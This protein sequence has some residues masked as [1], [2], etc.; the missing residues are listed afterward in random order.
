MFECLKV[1]LINILAIL[2]MS[3]KFA[4]LDLLK[5]KGFWSKVYDVIKMFMTKISIM[6]LK[7]YCRCGHVTKIW[8]LY[9]FYE[10]SY[11]SLNFYKDLTRKNN[12]FEGCLFKFNNLR[13][14][15]G[16]AKWLAKGLKLKVRKFCGLISLFVEATGE[17]LVGG[18]FCL[19]FWIGLAVLSFYYCICTRK[20]LLVKRQIVLKFRA[21]FE[22]VSMFP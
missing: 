16:M 21:K 15:L 6:W 12:I 9:N 8:K 5:L 7:L 4:T 11:H 2:M 19:L 3:A 22:R 10:S 13:L 17:K 14:A 20:Y 18:T 1:V